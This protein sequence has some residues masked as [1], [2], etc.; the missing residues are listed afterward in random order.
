MNL[1]VTGAVLLF[2]AVPLVSASAWAGDS[3]FGKTAFAGEIDK[4]AK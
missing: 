3:L 1:K 4:A 2:C